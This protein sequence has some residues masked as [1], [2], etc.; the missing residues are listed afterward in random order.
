MQ[1]YRRHVEDNLSKQKAAKK[2]DES[3]YESLN[4][5]LFH[6]QKKAKDYDEARKTYHNIMMGK[7]YAESE[8]PAILGLKQSFAGILIEQKNFEEAEPIARAVWDKRKQCPGPPS[9]STKETHRQ[10]CAVLC[11][12]GRYRDAEKMHR[13]IYQSETMDA[14][15]LENGDEVCQRLKEQGFTRKA[16]E[17]QDEVW[18]ERL[19]QH[20][21][22]EGSTIRSGL[23]LVGFLEELV[24]TMQHQGDNDAERRFYSSTKEVFECEIEL[25]LKIFWDTRLQPEPITDILNAGHK[26]GAILF[27]RNRFSDAEAIFSPVWEG[28]K[29]QLG[30]QDRGTISTGRMLGK[31]LCRQEKQETYRRAVDVLQGSWLVRDTVTKDDDA[32]ALSSIE[33]LA[34]AYFSLEKWLNAEATWE[35]IVQQKIQKPD[36]LP[37]EIDD[38]R[39]N[40]GQTLYQQGKEKHR[41]AE[42][43]LRGLYNQWNTS[44]PKPS[45]TLQCG[46]M[47]ARSLST[48]EG[49]T[50]DALEVA[51]N[52]F[53]GRETS[54]ERD[55]AYL[56]SSCLY[57]SLL[58]K[59]ENLAEA[60]RILKSVWEQEHSAKGDEEQKMWLKCGNLY[61]Q[62]LTKRRKLLQAKNI[63]SAIA[64][65]Q[66][67]ILPAENPEIIEAHRLLQVVSQQQKAGKRVK[68]KGFRR[69]FF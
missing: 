18:K 42:T 2:E 13:S 32:E 8:D 22:R 46:Q 41:K 4:I 39:W 61:A 52:L 51:L 68:K 60:E 25:V 65:G 28:M 5:A 10:L 15:A 47:L 33:D 36:C 27:F 12:M 50:K 29:Q 26:L 34:R 64:T 49:R 69:R 48:Q 59:A 63:L 67:A 6:S 35:W 14:W 3:K 1:R 17:L 66:Q 40:L 23:R 20:G 24:A 37:R 21:P 62:A 7:D 57:G 31:A 53:N 16:K 30:Q 58:L 44:S 55:L 43:V 11:A 45:Q 38:A 19:R 54:G 56:D 9:D